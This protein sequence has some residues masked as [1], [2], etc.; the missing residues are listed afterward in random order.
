MLV[1]PSTPAGGGRYYRRS[2]SCVGGKFA[3]EA[4]MA[5]MFD[6]RRGSRRLRIPQ[7]S[8]AGKSARV[9]RCAPDDRL[10]ASSRKDDPP[11]PSKN[12]SMKKTRLPVKPR[13]S[14]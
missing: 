7:S 9:A 14:G 11:H 13:L 12:E 8:C 2:N 4:M 5:A 10:R 1:G 3:P 6:T